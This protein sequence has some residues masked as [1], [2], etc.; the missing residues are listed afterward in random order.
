MTVS[1]ELRLHQQELGVI[2]QMDLDKDRWIQVLEEV[3]TNRNI[4]SHPKVEKLENTEIAKVRTG[5]YRTFVQRD[6][7]YLNILM[8]RHRKNAY[9]D[10]ETAVARAGDF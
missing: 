10:V 2:E 6:G 9:R 4:L 5:D 8:V 7:R 1:Y 3:A